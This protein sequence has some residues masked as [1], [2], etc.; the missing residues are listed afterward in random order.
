MACSHCKILPMPSQT[1]IRTT[2][3][4]FVLAVFM[5]TL[6]WFIF[7][8]TLTSVSQVAKYSIISSCDRYY[9][10]CEI[11]VFVWKFEYV[12]FF[13]LYFPFE[14]MGFAV[15]ICLVCEVVIFYEA[16][17]VKGIDICADTAHC[18]AFG[19]AEINHV[20]VLAYPEHKLDYIHG[21]ALGEPCE[22]RPLC[23]GEMHDKLK[24]GLFLFLSEWTQYLRIWSLY[25]RFWLVY[26]LGNTELVS[27]AIAQSMQN[28]ICC[29]ERLLMRS[30][31]A[32]MSVSFRP[33][34]YLRKGIVDICLWVIF[35]EVLHT[36][37]EI[38]KAV[39]TIIC[40]LVRVFFVGGY[41]TQAVYY[42][43]LETIFI[44]KRQK[45]RFISQFSRDAATKS[46]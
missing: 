9:P 40:A 18:P 17:V 23:L 28:N 41:F 43:L 42:E 21:N 6:S 7:L 2:Q 33:Y 45:K 36:Y 19:D 30:M 46:M 25:C 5:Q 39:Y 34:L 1:K 10:S 16:R 14:E 3:P 27:I 24:E 37:N 26:M 12:T 29:E 15:Y 35:T 44:P 31:S 13:Q 11:K 4:V 8:V 22:V 38:H 20:K 32:E